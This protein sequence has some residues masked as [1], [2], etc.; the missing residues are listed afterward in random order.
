[1][2]QDTLMS[3]F[4]TRGTYNLRDYLNK[5][6]LIEM[7][8]TL[9]QIVFRLD[10]MVLCGAAGT[11]PPSWSDI[12]LRELDVS[13]NQ[14]KGAYSKALAMSHRVGT[15]LEG[16]QGIYTRNVLGIMAHAQQRAAGLGKSMGVWVGTLLQACTVKETSTIS[17]T[18]QSRLLAS[19][20]EPRGIVC[21]EIVSWVE[22]TYM[23]GSLPGKL[24]GTDPVGFLQGP[25]RQAGRR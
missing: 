20:A 7:Q 19:W 2:L 3:R 18:L 17:A 10:C 23:A 12:P 21:R 5:Q 13:S 25:C 14:L 22:L 24:G 9:K 6:E 16:I 8:V 1:M 4:C 15:A 11:L